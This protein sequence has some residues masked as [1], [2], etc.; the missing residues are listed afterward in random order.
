MQH[1][2]DCVLLCATYCLVYEALFWVSAVGISTCFFLYWM[3]TNTEKIYYVSTTLPLLWAE[4]AATR[5]LNVRKMEHLEV[6]FFFRT[7]MSSSQNLVERFNILYIL[8]E[9]LLQLVILIS[10][11]NSKKYTVLKVMLRNVQSFVTECSKLRL[12]KVW[13]LCPSFSTSLHTH[14]Y[15]HLSRTFSCLSNP[16]LNG[17]FIIYFTLQLQLLFEL[18]S[19]SVFRLPLQLQFKTSQCFNNF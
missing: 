10:F 14:S 8:V 16:H 2:G 12:F 5:E 9:T 17:T 6:V 13:T 7:E 18:F 1:L 11:M 4:T 19:L 3:F 15:F